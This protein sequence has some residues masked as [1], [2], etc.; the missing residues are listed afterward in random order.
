MI[1][2]SW[3]FNFHI[4]SRPDPEAGHKRDLVCQP[5]PI[6]WGLITQLSLRVFSFQPW[7]QLRGFFAFRVPLP[8]CGAS[9]SQ[10]YSSFKILH[11]TFKCLSK[12]QF[13][14]TS[15][16]V[17]NSAQ[18]FLTNQLIQGCQ[19]VYFLKMCFLKDCKIL[20]WMFWNSNITHCA[21]WVAKEMCTNGTFTYATNNYYWNFAFV[22]Q[23]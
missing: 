6:K 11:W 7:K 9:L 22:R 14:P 1:C 15:L 19:T 12:V 23:P 2:L 4:I 8:D 13:L 5:R 18:L 20:K 16:E 21:T 3:H 17:F 10:K